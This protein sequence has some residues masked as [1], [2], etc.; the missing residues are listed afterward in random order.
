[1]GSFFVVS[2]VIILTGLVGL[3]M[4]IVEATWKFLR[5]QVYRWKEV[6]NG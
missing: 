2:F 1:M 4:A 3:V 6:C 5:N